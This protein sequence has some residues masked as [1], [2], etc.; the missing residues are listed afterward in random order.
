M[1][2][3]Y[4]YHH[5]R[6]RRRRH[7]IFATRRKPRF[8]FSFSFL[9]VLSTS[10]LSAS[11]LCSR[12]RAREIGQSKQGNGDTTEGTVVSRLRFFSECQMEDRTEEM[13]E[14]VVEE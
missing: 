9:R 3:Y 6:R 8:L 13:E 10:F 2:Y 14:E 7:P 11:P 1:R 5:H 4:Y 12:S